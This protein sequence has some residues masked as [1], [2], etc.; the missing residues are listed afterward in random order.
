MY[1]KLLFILSVFTFSISS[2]AW[3]KVNGDILIEGLTNSMTCK[4]MGTKTLCSISFKGNHIYNITNRKL[5]ITSLYIR[6]L[7]KGY[8]ASPEAS[9][10]LR[11][12]GPDGA[13]VAISDKLEMLNLGRYKSIKKNY[14]AMKQLCP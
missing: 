6:S 14:A 4:V 9:G 13:G 7:G 12:E 2:F 11:I 10:C 8:E 1:L 3:E 5:R